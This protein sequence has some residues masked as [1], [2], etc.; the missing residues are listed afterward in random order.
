[1]RLALVVAAV[2]VFAAPAFADQPAPPQGQP[3]PP[4]TVPGA[5]LSGVA[6]VRAARY[7]TVH[8]AGMV[9]AGRFRIDFAAGPGAKVVLGSG[10]ATVF[11]ALRITSMRWTANAVSMTGIGIVSGERVHFTA[12]AVDGVGRD[13]FRVDWKHRAA[14]GGPLLRGTVVIH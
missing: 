5:G 1:M 11:R 2:L 6:G 10:G 14:L 12:L 4:E 8:A 7:R 3:L 9:A 13:V